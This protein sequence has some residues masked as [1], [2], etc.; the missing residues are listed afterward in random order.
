MASRLYGSVWKVIE[1][2]EVWEED[3][4]VS[5]GS[6]R[7]IPAIYLRYWREASEKDPG[8]GKTRSYRYSQIDPSFHEHWEILYDW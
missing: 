8:T 4:T 1:E 5:N 3:A 7:L 6:A 2:K